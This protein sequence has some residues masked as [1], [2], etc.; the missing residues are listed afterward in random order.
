MVMVVAVGRGRAL[1]CRPLVLSDGVLL[2]QL[3][4]RRLVEGLHGGLHGGLEAVQAL[5]ALEGGR[6]V[7]QPLHRHGGP[8]RLQSRLQRLQATTSVTM[9]LALDIY[10]QSS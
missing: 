9:S 7:L 5:Q 2:R 6:H 1:G 10:S 8:A 3:Q 4:E